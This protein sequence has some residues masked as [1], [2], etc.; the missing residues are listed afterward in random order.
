VIKELSMQLADILRF[1]EEFAPLRLAEDWDNVGL[2]LGRH[3]A[4]VQKVL[5]CLTLTADVAAEAVSTGV[6]LIVTHHPILFRPI[7]RLTDATA[8][9]TM[10]LELIENHVAV[11]SPHTAF[12]SAFEGINA[13]WSAQLGLEECVP[14]RPLMTS[15]SS[16]P[17]ESSQPGLGAGR[18]G[19]LKCPC[20]LGELVER[21]QQ[22]TGQSQIGFVGHKNQRIQHVGIACGAAAEMMK[23]ADQL[24]CDVLIT[25]EA[26]FH[27][28]LE[29]R[30]RKIGLILLGHFASE[31]FAC[32]QLAD[33]LGQ[34][35]PGLQVQASQAECDPVQWL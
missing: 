32:E 18:A 15:N 13:R 20:S 31:R 16:T 28:C 12:D 9:G 17:V 11:Y 33:V 22:L 8:E 14:L 24:G 35:F 4:D 25:G 1:L 3:N 34:Q 26:R 6:D 5:T 29:A 27:A 2:L 10:L 7:Q 19:R 21:L 23:E 30:S